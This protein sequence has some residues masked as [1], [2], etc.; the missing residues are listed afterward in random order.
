MHKF[1]LAALP[2]FAPALLA[3]GSPEVE[4]NNDAATATP[5][6]LGTQAEGAIDFAGDF[7][8]Y[9][10]T[11]ASASDLRFWVNPGKVATLDDSDLALIASDGTTVLVTNDDVSAATNWLSRIVAGNLAAGDYYLRVRSS[12]TYDPTGVGSYTLDVVAAAPGTYVA[13][14]GALSPITEAAENNDPRPA[15]GS[16]TATVSAIYTQN[17]GNTIAGGS[18]GT[19]ETIVGKDYDFYEFVAPVP[20]TYTFSTLNSASAP[21]PVID[22]TVVRLFDGAFTSLAYNDDAGGGAYS[23]LSYNITTPGTY[24]VCVSGYYATSADNYYLD[25]ELSSLPTG[26]ASVTIQAGGCGPTL[27]NRA[28]NQGDRPEVPVLGSEFYLD[29]AGL[30]AFAGT[31]ELVGFSTLPVPF[32]LGNVGGPLGCNVEV[33]P[34]SL[35]F[36]VADA[37][38]EVSWKFPTPLWLGLIGLPLEQQLVALSNTQVLVASNRVTSVCG[39]T[40]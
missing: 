38:G 34:L 20:G 23:F 1:L 13:L 33:N 9:K 31:F 2:L 12:Q 36:V 24:Y 6:A 10:I 8:F 35:V 27:G 7:D 3:Q 16:G 21:A 40:N 14:S 4:P 11:L 25:I 37:A 29:G 26:A 30:D 5:V 17:L 18:S 32:D 39:V 22:D 28:C 15:F 19:G